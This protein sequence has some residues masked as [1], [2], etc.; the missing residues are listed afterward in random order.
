[1]CIRALATSLYRSLTHLSLTSFLWDIGKQQI[2]QN[3]AS[4]L[5]LLCLYREISS[6]NEIKK[7][8]IKSL[9]TS[10]K[11]ESGFTQLIIQYGLMYTLVFHFSEKGLPSVGVYT[12]SVTGSSVQSL[13]D[14][15]GGSVRGDV[16]IGA[17]QDY[18]Q[19]VGNEERQSRDDVREAESC[20]EVPVIL[21]L[22]KH[23]YGI[24]SSFF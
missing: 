17:I 12:K 13:S 7:D 2:A 10:P 21:A 8:K 3:A 16:Q 1:M 4:H 9:Q 14:T 15:L 6:K 11:N 19:H 22:R 23:A 24:H 20:Y 5:G 18:R